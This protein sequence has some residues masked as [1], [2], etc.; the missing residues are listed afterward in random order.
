MT[1]VSYRSNNVEHESKE[2]DELD[3]LKT[4]MSGAVDLSKTGPACDPP[5][6]VDLSKPVASNS[7]H[8]ATAN[9]MSNGQ[10]KI[11]NAVKAEILFYQDEGSRTTLASNN[12][13]DR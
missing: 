6:A 2:T 3:L 12:N 1:D 5:H 7:L 11:I 13:N 4:K 9:Q 10:D 8:D